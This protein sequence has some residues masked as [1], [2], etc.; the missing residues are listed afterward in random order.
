MTGLQYR[1][2]VKRERLWGLTLSAGSFIVLRSVFFSP[3][4]WPL[5]PGFF[6]TLGLLWGISLALST[7]NSLTLV[8]S[9]RREGF[10]D[11]DLSS[12]SDFWLRT[13]GSIR[14]PVMP[15]S[16]CVEPS[17]GSGVARHSPHAGIAA[18]NHLLSTH[19][20]FLPAGDEL[21]EQLECFRESLVHAEKIGATFCL[22]PTGVWSGC[23]ETNLGL[24]L[25]ATA[26]EP[27]RPPTARALPS[28]RVRRVDT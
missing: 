2:R 20:P 5:V 19:R 22:L 6:A 18:I 16:R 11:L 14:D 1:R 7:V 9:R 15:L 23:A 27:S 26:R 12:I 21:I 4:W 17:I 13:S 10:S 8:C 24:Y 28:S 25:W 3:A